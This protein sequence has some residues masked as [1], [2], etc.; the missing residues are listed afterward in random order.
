[1][2]E[3]PDQIAARCYGCAQGWGRFHLAFADDLYHALPDGNSFRRC[4]SGERQNVAAEIE[5]AERRGAAKA[6]RGLAEW[7]SRWT[8]N[9]NVCSGHDDAPC[10]HA[11]SYG[12]MADEALRRAE[13]QE[14]PE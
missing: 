3:T 14:K 1:M 4:F 13:E 11:R 5:R 6:L 8:E 7:A 9:P 2:T 10:C 12:N